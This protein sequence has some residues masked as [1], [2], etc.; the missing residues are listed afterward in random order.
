MYVIL[1]TKPGQF[2]T[3]PGK[4]LRSVEAYDYSMCGKLKAHFV[5]AELTGNESITIVDEAPPPVVNQIPTK[6]FAKYDTVEKA[7][8]ELEHLMQF[9]SVQVALQRVV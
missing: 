9:G 4:H 3:E 8:S 7:R 1:T 2:R 6:L 5:I